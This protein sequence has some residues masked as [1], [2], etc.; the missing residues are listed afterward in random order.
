M[1]LVM[2]LSGSETYETVLTGLAFSDSAFWFFGEIV[3]KF[4]VLQSFQLFQ[5]FISFSG[6][7]VFR[8]FS[9]FIVFRFADYS[10]FSKSENRVSRAISGSLWQFLGLSGNFQVSQAISGSLRIFFRFSDFSGNQVCRICR[11][12]EFAKSLIEEKKYAGWIVHE[13][14]S[15]FTICDMSSIQVISDRPVSLNAKVVY[16]QLPEKDVEYKCGDN[17]NKTCTK[18]LAKIILLLIIKNIRD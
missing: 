12:A 4:Q 17:R 18:L 6:S 9:F 8:I 5:T 3:R 13:G 16:S 14:Q 11:Y 10:K 2:V 1:L 15:E 7:S